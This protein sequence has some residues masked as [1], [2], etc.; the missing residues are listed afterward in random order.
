MRKE[1]LVQNVVMIVL[2]AAV[3]VMSIG[4]AVYAQTLNINGSATFSKAV[5][6]VHFDTTTFNENTTIT[7]STKDVGNT[8]I[9]YEVTLAK[10][11]DEYEFSVNAKNFGT[12][13][14]LLKKITLSGLTDAQKKFINYTVTYNGTDYTETTDGLA[15][16]LAGNAS[17]TVK[18]HVEYLLP[19][20]AADLPSS[21]VT[22]ALT[23][24]LDYEAKTN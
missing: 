14:A 5:W 16:S 1:N 15:I 6:D 13:E 24:G 10:P 3:L 23:V 20:A 7:A 22:V 2:A 17:H 18:V 21:D 4:Y 12:I 11:G 19:D 9:T 8:L